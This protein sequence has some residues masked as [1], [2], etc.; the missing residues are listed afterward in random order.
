MQGDMRVRVDGEFMEVVEEAGVVE[1]GAGHPVG[2]C[3]A[4]VGFC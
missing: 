3:D 1:R 4:L 2:E